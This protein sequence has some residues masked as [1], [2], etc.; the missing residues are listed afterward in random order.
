MV[1]G[2]I[3]IVNQLTRECKIGEAESLNVGAPEPDWVKDY[4]SLHP[5]I[6]KNLVLQNLTA[7]ESYIF[8]MMKIRHATAT[9]MRGWKTTEYQLTLD[10]TSQKCSTPGTYYPTVNSCI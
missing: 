4:K 3:M 2:Q 1:T 6:Y 8:E 5:H 10:Q 7:I 9:V